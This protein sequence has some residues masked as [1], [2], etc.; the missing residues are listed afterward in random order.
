M[1]KIITSLVLCFIVTSIFSITVLATTY[2]SY[3]EIDY[4]STLTGAGRTYSGTT[5]RIDNKLT[6]RYY[7]SGNNYCDY[8]LQR[9]SGSSYTTT[10]TRTLNLVSI[11]NT[12]SATYSNQVSSGTFRYY[13]TNR[14]LSSDYKYSQVDAFKC[15]QVTMSSY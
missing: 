9:L 1:K 7:N 15:D 6:S 2:T 12:Y 11:G 8:Y 10:G 13:L 14:Y 4:R 5:H 3:I